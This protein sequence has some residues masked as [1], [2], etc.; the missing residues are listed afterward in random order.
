MGQKVSSDDLVK[1]V[2]DALEEYNDMTAL[3]M[4]EI[5][6]QV[7]KEGA[8]KLKQTSPRSS[9]KGG[10]KG[11]YADGWSVKYVKISVNRFSFVIHN[12]KK[13]GLAHLLE[14]GHQLHQGGRAP[15]IPHIK[16]VEEWCNEEFER[17]VEARLSQGQ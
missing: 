9:G 7:A 1:A 11:H 10:P 16:E 14:N 2:M 4:E 13:P 3:E 15:A 8:K 5:A 6:K 12:R 17:R